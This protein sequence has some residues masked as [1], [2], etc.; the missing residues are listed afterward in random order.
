[1]KSLGIENAVIFRGWLS[2][3]EVLTY[4]RSADVFVFPSLRDNGAGVVFETLASGAVPVVADF[5]GPGDIVH[6]AVG[7][8]VSLTNDND[9]VA[10][11]ERVLNE[12]AHDRDLLRR[13]RKHGM[14]YARE[15][16][17]WDAKAQDTT[18]VL[19]WVVGRGVKPDLEPPKKLTTLFS[20][21]VED[22]ESAAGARSAESFRSSQEKLLERN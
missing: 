8:K 6:S 18:K 19:D 13:L 15:R 16:L 12:L 22:I 17:T 10:Q 3:S 5:G 11:L 2:H 9:I 4:M 14:S 1:M 21:R 7:Y 20:A